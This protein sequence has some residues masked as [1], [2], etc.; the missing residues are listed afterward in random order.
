MALAN[1]VRFVWLDE[2]I[3]RVG[4][5]QEFKRRFRNT[6]KPTAA[7]PP[8]AINVTIWTLEQNAAPFLFASTPDE[9]IQ[10]IEKNYDKYVIFISS[11]SLGQTIIPRI[12][13]TYPCVHSFYI[14]CG[15]ISK[16][17][18]LAIEFASCLQTF[19]H[20]TDLLVR[21]ARDISGDI[22]KQGKI[23]MDIPEPK[24]ALKCYDQALILNNEVNR[25]DTLN[26]PCYIYIREINGDG[27]NVGLI[28]EAQ[29]ML[30]Q[31]ERQQE[32]QREA[33]G[34]DQISQQESSR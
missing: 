28:Q 14:F 9:A 34:D 20:E 29:Y 26:D 1:G 32:R 24:N 18:E 22:I 5:Y 12:S 30:Y 3:G 27:L 33:E 6:L 2:H 23:Y 13:A 17:V 25:I 19:N 31:Q 4:K 21:L 16:Y 15:D 7:A 11:G 10:L 8:D